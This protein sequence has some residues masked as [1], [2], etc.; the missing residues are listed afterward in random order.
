MSKKLV[1]TLGL[2]S[3]PLIWI[4][5]FPVLVEFR[6]TDEFFCECKVSIYDEIFQLKI[7]KRYLMNHKKIEIKYL[8]I[9]L[10]YLL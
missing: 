7:K 1:A 8:C 9:I 5:S 3:A 10:K 6:N 4:N 2:I